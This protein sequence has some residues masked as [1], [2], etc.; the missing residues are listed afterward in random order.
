MIKKLLLASA[1]TALLTGAASAAD[2]P[3]RAAPPPVFTPVPVFTWTG[4]Y[5][6]INAGYAVDASSRSNSSVFGV[7]APF[8]AAGSTATFRDRSQ[9]GFSRGAQVAY[10]YQ[11]TPVSGVV[12]GL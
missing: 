1:A 3:R 6:G 5:F 11:F 10:N 4:A 7:L 12:V 8:A 9:D 2:L